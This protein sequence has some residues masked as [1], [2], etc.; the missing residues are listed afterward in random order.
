MGRKRRLWNTI[1]MCISLPAGLL[2]GCGKEPDGK[3]CQ[4]EILLEGGRMASKAMMPEE[5]KISDVNLLVFDS[6]GQIVENIYTKGESPLCLKL[7]K[8]E[9]YHFAGLANFGYKVTA[10]SLDDLKKLSFHLAY[11]DEYREGLPMASDVVAHKIVKDMNI[12]L[13]L[14]NMMSKI[15]IRI[16]RNHLSDNIDMTVSGLRIGNCPR[17][18]L[19][20]GRSMVNDESDNFNVG[21]SL[22]ALECSGLNRAEHPGISEEVCVYM[23]ENMQG[24]F[25]DNDITSDEQKVIPQDDPRFHTCSYIEMDI[26]YLS[27]MW[28]SGETPLT[29]RFYLGDG[30]NNLDVE[31]NC[32]YHITVTPEDDGLHGEGWRVDKTGLQYNG[33]TLFEPYPSDYIVGDIGDRIHIGCRVTPSHTSFDIGLE[34]LEDDK[35]AGI[36][37][38][39]VD[40][41]GHG[42]TLTLTAPGSGLI[43]MEAGPPVNEGAL[44]LIEVNTPR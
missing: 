36:Y 17:K 24:R 35:A 23:L 31:R 7:I 33:P 34:Y 14:V 28:Q 25:A 6:H 15:S 30:L 16:N 44:F 27:D 11:P 2:C 1:L 9:T 5:G 13:S 20:F 3:T 40:S 21:F 22:S 41:D 43:Y 4:V 12:R 10:T 29:Y 18:A 37:N 32:H 42:V 26:D 8:D 19:V 38:Y 39:Q